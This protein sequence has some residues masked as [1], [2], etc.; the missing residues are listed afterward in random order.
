MK[1]SGKLLL[2]ASLVAGG[3]ALPA[4]ATANPVLTYAEDRVHDFL[5]IFRVRAGL[6][7][8]GKGVGV[9]AR[10]T[11]LAQAGYMYF[12]G[13]YYGMDRRGLGVVDEKRFE[14]GVSLLY[15]SLNQM[16]PVHGNSFLKG[17]MLWHEV[18]DRRIIRNLPHW[19]D[20]RKRP[21][22][23]GFEIATPLIAFDMGV[24][25]TEALDFALGIFTIDMHR[26]DQLRQSPPPYARPRTPPVVEEDAPF[27]DRREKFDDLIGEW[28]ERAAMERLAEMGQ[29]PPPPPA[30]GEDPWITEEEADAAIEELDRQ[31]PPPEEP[32]DEPDDEPEEEPEPEEED[33][34]D[35]NGEDEDE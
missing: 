12:D 6:P 4:P 11:S 18:A 22:S 24:Y 23:V 27:S 17:D 31:P 2:L 29:L 21:L 16:E 15:G 14:G 19:D 3:L 8:G 9:K 13:T 33:N 30:P 32:E 35:E 1:H 20:G 25:P 7:K 10:V 26:D 28:E 34:G 5:D